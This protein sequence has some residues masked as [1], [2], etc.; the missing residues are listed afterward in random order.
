MIFNSI[1]L[2]K[3]LSYGLLKRMKSK[4]SK[5]KKVFLIVVVEVKRK[6]VMTMMMTRKMKINQR[7]GMNI[8]FRRK[9][10][11]KRKKIKKKGQL[12]INI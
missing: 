8:V 12:I 9:N 11:K 4:V 5:K 2:K 1:S 10:N 6:E 7:L 3:S